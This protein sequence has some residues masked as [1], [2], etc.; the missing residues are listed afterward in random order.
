MRYVRELDEQLEPKLHSM[1]GF[2]S[3][4]E[5]RGLVIIFDNVMKA[6]GE[7]TRRRKLRSFLDTEFS[8]IPDNLFEDIFHHGPIN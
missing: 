1:R 7:A 4:L 2:I 6:N 8:N 3:R 5:Q